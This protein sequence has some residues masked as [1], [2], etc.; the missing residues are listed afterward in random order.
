LRYAYSYTDAELK[1]FVPAIKEADVQTRQ[2]YA[3]FNNCH[4]GSATL[5]AKR[6][7]ELLKTADG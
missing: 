2:T 6:L 3:M 4:R 7:K 5:N 1:S